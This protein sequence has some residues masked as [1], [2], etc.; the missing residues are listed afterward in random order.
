MS[1]HSSQS[2]VKCWNQCKRQFKYKYLDELEPRFGSIPLKLGSWMHEL[3]AAHHVE[4][5]WKKRHRKL[6]KKFNT[7]L[8][9]ERDHYGPVPERAHALM[10]SYEYRYRDDDWEILYAEEEFE[11]TLK[12]GYTFSITPDLI[13]R[14]N[15]G[16]VMCIDH[17][18]MKDIPPAEARV[19]DMQSV[20]YPAVLAKCG[21]HTDAFMFNY[22]RT[23]E[24]TVPH[25]NQDGTMS[26]AKCNT[27]YYT[28][29][30]FVKE[31]DVPL[32]PA[33]KT[34]LKHLKQFNP[35]FH[36]VRFIKP[37]VVSRRLM[38]EVI[39]TMAEIEAFDR[40]RKDPWVR[41]MQKS[42]EWSCDF[43][44]LCMI[45]LIGGNATHLRKTKYRDSEY[46][47]RKRSKIG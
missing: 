25:L 30:K 43:Y 37:E 46:A 8:L 47:K 38:R 26:K 7:L 1:V 42:C 45:E 23:K 4:G 9:E 34:R 12:K 16:V 27:D 44:D 41:S 29:A 3:I 5:D 14:T 2:A 13:V 11:A 32:T 20:V 24:P 21:V 31:H 6:T 18:N 17:K 15:D 28:L 10:S 33:L 35:F 36:R 39:L 22:I 40:D 19:G